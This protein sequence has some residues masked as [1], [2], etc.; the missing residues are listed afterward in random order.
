M[1]KHNVYIPQLEMCLGA[2]DDVFFGRGSTLGTS[3]SIM[4]LY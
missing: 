4:N 1:N 3:T 2:D